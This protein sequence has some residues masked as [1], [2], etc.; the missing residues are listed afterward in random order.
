MPDGIRFNHQ[1]ALDLMWIESNPVLHV[2]DTHTHFSEL[3][4]TPTE[5]H[6][7]LGSGERYHSPLRRI[8][9]KIRIDFPNIPKEIARTRAT[10]KNAS[11]RNGQS[12][13][14]TIVAKQR[15]ST[16][17]KRKLPPGSTMAITAGT[18]VL[19]YREKEKKWVGPAE[20][21]EVEG[22][23]IR[24]YDCRGHLKPF[25]ISAV[26]PY[27]EPSNSHEALFSRIREIFN[28]GSAG[29]E[30]NVRSTFI[31]EVLSWGDPRKKILAFSPPYEKRVRF[32]YAIKNA[33]TPEEQFKIRFVAQGHT[34]R[35]KY[36]L[37]HCSTT[38]H[39]Y[40]IRLISDEKLS[41]EVYIRPSRDFGLPQGRFLRLL[42]PLYG[43]S[44]AGDYW[45]A[46]K[47]NHYKSD[48][49]MSATVGDA[50]LFF[51]R[52]KSK[53][54]GLAR[55]YVDDSLLCGNKKFEDLTAKT[56]EVFDSQDRVFDNV[57]FS[58]I[59]IETAESGF[60]LSQGNYVD[61]LENLSEHCNNGGNSGYRRYQ[62]GKQDRQS[63]EK[64]A[65]CLIRREPR[66]YSQLG[67]AIFLSDASGACNL[68]HFGSYKDK[69]VTRAILAGEIHAFSTTFDFA[70]ILQHALKD[71]LERHIPIHMFTD[72]KSLFDLVTKASYTA[73]KRLMIDAQVIREAFRRK[74]SI[75]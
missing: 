46:T 28:T 5:S 73:E 41:R 60:Y 20:V 3:R 6:N 37:V 22:K 33:G 69:R 61:N 23:T 2:V 17:L 39:Q 58:G 8:F 25:S 50:S 72:S 1:L 57:N 66:L 29:L 14:E 75:T 16:A 49:G 54:I 62:E 52:H 15:I 34:D 70:Y 7:S 27:I 13:D 12:R 48:L 11:R 32:V 71:I 51:K 63:S 40:S 67:M 9:L 42:L 55:T 18:K 47:V 43:L 65:Q 31:T 44:D 30:S 38:L 53:L 68:I 56:S 24:V 26:K 36:Y 64:D 59:R 35:G 74:K 19:I 21:V 4:L 10:R 45:D